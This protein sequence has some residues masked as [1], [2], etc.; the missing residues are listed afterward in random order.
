MH[1]YN[2][3]FLRPIG[4]D[5]TTDPLDKELIGARLFNRLSVL[6]M[7][8]YITCQKKNYIT[9]LFVKKKLLVSSIVVPCYLPSCVQ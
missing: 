8:S 7:K 4:P 1:A 3:S 9:S 5:S 6:L 2:C